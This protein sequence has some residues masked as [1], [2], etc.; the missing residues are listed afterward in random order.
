MCRGCIAFHAFPDNGDEHIN[1]G[2]DPDLCLDGILRRTEE[3]LN[4][5]MLFD[6]YMV[7]PVCQALNH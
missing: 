2:G 1:G 7:A 4:P 3:P 5:Q 6:P